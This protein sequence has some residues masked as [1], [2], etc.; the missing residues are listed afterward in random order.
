[1]AQAEKWKKLQKQNDQEPLDFILF[2][3]CL[4][5]LAQSNFT[6][7]FTPAGK[8]SWT[9]IS[10]WGLRM[11]LFDVDVFYRWTALMTQKQHFVIAYLQCWSSYLEKVISYW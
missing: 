3:W 7:K 6:G 5:E 11:G 9:T 1:M 2:F 10:P 4:K 8:H